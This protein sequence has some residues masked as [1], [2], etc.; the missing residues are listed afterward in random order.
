M[1][2]SLFPP[3]LFSEFRRIRLRRKTPR[4][5]LSIGLVRNVPRA[6]RRKAPE[7][8]AST[9]PQ[10]RVGSP[11]PRA[12]ALQR[13]SDSDDWCRILAAGENGRYHQHQADKDQD[14]DEQENESN[15]GVF[16]RIVKVRRAQKPMRCEALEQAPREAYLV[17]RRPRV[18]REGRAR[19]VSRG[20]V[21]A[22]PD[23]G[24]ADSSRF[25]WSLVF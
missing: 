20:A 16:H 19:R 5:L 25:L 23:H 18:R 6:R 4:M 13:R 22:L 12:P 7:V 24:A 11:T 2:P 1:A 9:P 8:L 17:V 10:G 15:G 3:P 21:R 14:D